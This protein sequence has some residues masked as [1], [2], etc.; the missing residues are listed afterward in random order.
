MLRN[1][2]KIALRNLFKEK[3]Y[4][5]INLIGL[6]V[7]VAVAALIMLYAKEEWSFDKFHSN[8]DRIYRNWVKEHYE[9]ELF[10]NVSTPF[11]LGRE[12]EANFPEIEAVTR[13]MPINDL[14]QKDEF[15][16]QENIHLVSPDF[17][18]VFDF[19]LL[20]GNPRQVFSDLNSVVLTEEMA[21]KY[22][23]FDAPVGESLSIQVSGTWQEFQVAGIIEEAPSNSSLQYDILI[24]F[25]HVKTFVS[26]RARNSWTN[27]NPETYVLLQE[28]ADIKA[29]EA[30]VATFIDEKVSRIYEP[31]EY[32]VGFQP[33]EDV[34]LNTDIPLG[35]ASVS[36][37]RYPYI[38]SAIAILILL[39]AAI[40][41]V[42][43]AVG[44]SVSRAKEVGVRKVSGATRIQLMLQFWSEA[45][46]LSLVA[47]GLGL[48]VTELL[49][50]LFNQLADKQLVFQYNWENI[51][52]LLTLVV[53]L[54]LISGIYP[55]LV[56]SGFSPINALKDVVTKL[57]TGKHVVLRGLVGAQF[58][59]SIGLITC[60]F[61]MQGQMRFLQ[62][63]NLG[64]NKEQMLVL[65]YS[66]SP[67]VERG[68]SAI[69]EEGLQT[70]EIFRQEL[71]GNAGVLG[72]TTS[73]HAF[74][75][76]GWLQVGYTDPASQKYRGFFLNRVDYHYIPTMDIALKSG[77]N[78]SEAI[79]TDANT[80]VIINETMAKQYGLEDGVGQQLP[81]P[82]EAFE[83]IGI[84][85]DFNFTS[86]HTEVEPLVMA[87]NPSGIYDQISDA[88]YNDT[89]TPKMTIKIAGNNIPAT[90]K[91]VQEAWEKVAPDQ[92]FD[93]TFVD[94]AL[95]NQ[96]RAEDRL[97][98]I[99]TMATILAIFIACLGLFGIATLTIAR[100]TKE[101]G[102]RKVLGASAFNIVILLNKN[103]AGIVIL[104][105]LIA[106]PLSYYFMKEWLTDFAYQVSIN[107]LIFLLATV[108]ALVIAWLAVSY[109]SL[110]A[111]MSNPV[112]ALKYE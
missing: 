73:A 79:G 96:Y 5:S 34:H 78:F 11:I 71:I 45:L 106:T 15:S 58:V 33:L 23:G 110:R 103:F 51:G 61:I 31:G 84:V 54:G 28:G 13:Y 6:S 55:A 66:A 12:L 94:Q 29:L 80:A 69:F 89:P 81:K 75:T 21:N 70:A 4:S 27:V 22:F 112:K 74:G 26:E 59:L 41:F 8:S 76:Q 108:V 86:L 99:L 56:I 57:G 65:P 64:Y 18:K 30:K 24:A 44:R 2:L 16:D 42:T 107:P 109:H 39:L 17:L 82:F 72:L 25:D 60:T 14:V 49:L 19:K 85:K 38:L 100:R 90:I 83:L 37:G 62:Q 47:M 77:R 50:P 101:I 3:L 53:V 9:G 35:Y 93:F 91:S 67:S 98:Q 36:D 88:S 105:S 43:L 32:I 87:V 7:G 1:Y 92:S 20:Q 40:N 68:I 63:K 95:D 52:F 46:V 10:F 111:A 97:S 102:I 104:A 48:L